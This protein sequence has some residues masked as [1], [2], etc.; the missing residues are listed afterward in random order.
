MAV[1]SKKVATYIREQ[2]SVDGYKRSS[3]EDAQGYPTLYVHDR[4]TRLP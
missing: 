1:Q 3:G 4:P 2:T